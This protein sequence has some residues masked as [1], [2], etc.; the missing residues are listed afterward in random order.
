M[1]SENVAVR[2]IEGKM[3]KTARTVYQEEQIVEM[4]PK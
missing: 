1:E 2:V 3:P 4:M